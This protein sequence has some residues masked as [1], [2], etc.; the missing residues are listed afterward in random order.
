M[1]QELRQLAAVSQ[2]V[3]FIQRGHQSTR[4][5]ESCTCAG[6]HAGSSGGLRLHK[7]L[8]ACMAVRV[9]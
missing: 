7:A 1:H 6:L 5:V 3:A 4:N 9:N 2:G 8:V